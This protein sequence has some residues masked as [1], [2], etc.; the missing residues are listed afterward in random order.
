MR[1]PTFVR[2]AVAGQHSG[3]TVYLYGSDLWNAH[4]NEGESNFYWAPL[5][6]SANGAIQPIGCAAT[7]TIALADDVPGHQNTPRGQDQSSGAT[8]F[9]DSCLITGGTQVAQTFTAGRSG[10]LRQVTVAA[11]QETTPAKRSGQLPSEEG[12]SPN[13]PLTLSL[14]SSS[15]TLA[16]Q[17]FDTN[18]VGWAPTQLSMTAN[19][20]VVAG[21]QYR[22]VVSSTASQGCY[23][24]LTNDANPYR[25]GE[26]S[27]G[28]TAKPGTDLMFSTAVG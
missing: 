26:L 25:G 14:V 8:G 28:G 11:Y 10:T 15:G 18:I 17:V 9:T 12:P 21:R 1:R 27:V 23:G 24:V 3:S 7:A 16:S 5:Q 20:P 4:R 6:F 22:V 19:T 13:A 2:R